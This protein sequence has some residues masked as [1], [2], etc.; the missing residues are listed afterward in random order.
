MAEALLPDTDAIPRATLEWTEYRGKQLVR[1]RDAAGSVHRILTA[2]YQEASEAFD[3]YA[4][5]MRSMAAKGKS[6]CG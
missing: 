3:R 4:E 5:Q 2:N 1:Y 6:R